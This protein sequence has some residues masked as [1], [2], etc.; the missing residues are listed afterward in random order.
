MG[1]TTK[2]PLVS[3]EISAI[4]NSYIGESLVAHIIEYFSSRADDNEIGYMLQHILRLSN[5]RIK[6]LTNLFNQEKL[7]LPEAFTDSDVDVNAPR[8][9]TD[10]L[11]LQYAAY[12][13]RASVR[14]Y[15]VILSRVTRSDIREYFSK[16]I[17]ESIDVYNRTAELGLSKGIFIKAPQVE[18]SKKVQY[19]KSKSFI[20]DML[21]KKRA[22]LTDEIADIVSIANDTVIRKALIIGFGQVC[23]NKEV[24]DYISRVMALANKQNDGLNSFLIDEGIPIGIPS[25]S[26]VTDSTISPFSDKIMLNKILIMYRLKI[27]SIGIALAN[28]MRSDLKVTYRKYL[29]E[30]MEYSKDGMDIMIDNGWLEQPPQAINHENLAKV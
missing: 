16:C 2:T 28:I 11:Y 29:D 14:S 17:E 26:Y 4:W 20:L 27:N 9:F 13:A 23:K 30:S 21:G 19:I 5:K 7:P 22:L 12:E 6:I 8:L 15:S 18:V 24:S 1:S 3:S 25:D 10:I